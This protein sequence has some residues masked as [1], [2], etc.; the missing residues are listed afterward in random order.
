MPL[1]EY[2]EMKEKIEELKSESIYHFIDVNYTNFEKNEYE[3][4]VNTE[5]IIKRYHQDRG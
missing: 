4:K 3:V 2:E 5:G 1:K